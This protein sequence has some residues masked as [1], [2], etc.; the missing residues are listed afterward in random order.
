LA[1]LLGGLLAQASHRIGVEAGK[2][3]VH[4]RFKPIPTR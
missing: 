4:V 3:L 2:H 1:R